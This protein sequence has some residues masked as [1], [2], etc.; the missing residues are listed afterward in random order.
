VQRDWRQGWMLGGSYSYVNTR[1]L[2]STSAQDLFALRSDPERRRV[3]NAPA[4][5][6]SIKGAVPIIGRHVTAASRLSLQGRHYDRFEDVGDEPQRASDLAVLWDVV[7]SGHEP[8]WGL[9]WALG[10]YNAFDWRYSL[11]V[12]AEFTQR[13]IPQIGRAFLAS[14][15]LEL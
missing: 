15:T 5:L 12:S 13:N 11:P 14:A 6:A 3:A 4:H 9:R 2:R 7:L 10:A 8:R 1:Y